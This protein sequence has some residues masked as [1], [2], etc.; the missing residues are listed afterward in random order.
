MDAAD[1]RVRGVSGAD[2]A[3]DGFRAENGKDEADGDQGATRRPT[4]RRWGGRR[5]WV[6]VVLA[7]LVFDVLAFVLIPPFVAGS[8]GTAAAYPADFITATFH[9]PP[10]APIFSLDGSEPPHGQLIYFHPSISNTILTSWIV[11]ALIL[12]VAFAATRRLRLHPGPFQNAVEY[13]LESLAGF[14]HGLGGPRARRYVP[15]FA[16]FFVFILISNWSGLV[17][18]VGQVEHLRAPT[19]DLNITIG[20]A[21]VSFC[22]FHIEGVRSLGLRGY[23]GKFFPLGEFRNGIAGGLIALVVG[24]VEFFLEFIKP[25]TLSMRLFGNIYGGELALAVVTALTVAVIPVALYGL[26][27]LLNFVQALIFSVLTLMFTLIAIE[28]HDDGEH[29]AAD[30]STTAAAAASHTTEGEPLAA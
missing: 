21:L 14:A 20:L 1:G 30:G 27:L 10:P 16:A 24:L 26:E 5:F 25:V 11:M 13:V 2:L 4:N 23:L 29:G 18:M 9:F 3:G 22:V 6:G 19:S 15:L 28:G 8:P 7:L 12:L 17:P